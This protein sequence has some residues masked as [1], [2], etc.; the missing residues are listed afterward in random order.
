MIMKI[1]HPASRSRSRLL[2]L[3]AMKVILPTDQLETPSEMPTIIPILDAVALTQ[4]DEGR[5]EVLIFIEN[6]TTPMVS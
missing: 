3:L 1:I 5:Y 6:E 2:L 4:K